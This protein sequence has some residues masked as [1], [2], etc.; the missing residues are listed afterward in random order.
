MQQFS[1]SSFNFCGHQNTRF[2]QRGEA[3]RTTL[4]PVLKPAQRSGTAPPVSGGGGGGGGGTANHAHLHPVHG[5]IQDPRQQQPSDLR[6]ERRREHL[7]DDR[8]LVLADGDN[9]PEQ[10]RKGTR[11]RRRLLEVSPL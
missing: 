8:E 3:S 11:R 9:A 4:P 1:K 7:P 10:P 2:A 5:V 6:D